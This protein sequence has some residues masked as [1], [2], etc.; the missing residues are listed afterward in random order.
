MKVAKGAHSA[1]SEIDTRHG[2]VVRWGTNLIVAYVGG[3]IIGAP[4]GLV[5]YGMTH[6]D[7]LLTGAILIS[8]IGVLIWRLTTH[9][10]RSSDR[11]F[12]KR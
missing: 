7:M 11:Q 2:V 6:V 3:L 12:T 4:I 1:T 9:G 5:L 8:M 10:S